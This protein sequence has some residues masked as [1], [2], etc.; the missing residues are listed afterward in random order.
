MNMRELKKHLA[1]LTEKELSN[2][3]SFFLK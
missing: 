1:E 2:E 3:V